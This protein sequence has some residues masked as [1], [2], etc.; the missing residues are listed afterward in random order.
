MSRL[1]IYFAS[2]YS[3]QPGQH[4][5]FKNENHKGNTGLKKNEAPIVDSSISPLVVLM[6][7][8]QFVFNSWWNTL[9]SVH[10]QTS[11]T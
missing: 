9:V 5:I 7:F 4:V 1:G 10:R 3:G 2:N 11:L 6:L 8:L